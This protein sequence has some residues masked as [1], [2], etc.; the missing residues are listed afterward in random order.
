MH[1]KRLSMLGA[2]VLS[3]FVLWPA[4]VVLASTSTNP[5]KTTAA[6]SPQKN[7]SETRTCW[8]KGNRTC[9]RSGNRVTCTRSRGWHGWEGRRH[10]WHGWHGWEGRWHGSWHGGEWRGPHMGSTH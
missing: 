9:C 5:A 4:G 3:T 1:T 7:T 2:A 10:G 6:V 8:R